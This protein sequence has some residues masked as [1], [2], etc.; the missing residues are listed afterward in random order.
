MEQLPNVTTEIYRTKYSCLKMYGPEIGFDKQKL[1]E[2]FKSYEKLV[3]YC[4]NNYMT[5]EEVENEMKDF[6]N[7]CNFK[8]RLHL[9]LNG[10]KNKKCLEVTIKFSGTETP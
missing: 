1:I 2:E 8:A 10:R 5:I 6:V 4:L 7:F 9:E 3:G